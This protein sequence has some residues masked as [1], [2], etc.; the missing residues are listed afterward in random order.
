[1]KLMR[2]HPNAGRPGI[3]ERI[4]ELACMVMAKLIY[5]GMRIMARR[6]A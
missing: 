2:L 6:M 3:L 5:R 4:I 1:M